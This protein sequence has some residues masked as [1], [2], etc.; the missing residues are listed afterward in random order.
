MKKIA[1]SLLLSLNILMGAPLDELLKEV[2]HLTASQSKQDKQ[3]EKKF[4]ADLKLAK[5]ELSLMK[6]SLK[7]ETQE[8]Q[9]LKD[10]FGKNK[11]TLKTMHTELDAKSINLKDLFAIVRQES[12]DFSSLLKASMTS[13][14][15]KDREAFLNELSKSKNVPT[16]EEIREFWTL[17]MQE[18]IEAGKL[19]TS[20]MQIVLSTGEKVQ[21][22]VTRVGLFSAFTQEG[23]LR[24]DESMQAFVSLIRQPNSKY[25]SYIQTYNH[26]DNTPSPILIDPTRGVLFSM[27]KERAGILDRIEQGGIIGYII[28]VLGAI[29]MAFA[30]YKYFSL[31]STN[32]K[33]GRQLVS[34]E[35]K[36]NNPL[37]RILLAFNSHKSKDIASLESKMDTAIL[38][39]LPAIQTGLPMIKLVAA[40]APLLGLLGTVTGMIETFQSI[41]L[42]GTG[43]PKLMAGGISQALMTTVLGLVVA[44]PIL[45]VFSV[46]NSQSK[47]IIEML[48]QQSSA[49]VAK[50]L[51]LI[52]TDV[53]SHDQSIN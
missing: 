17:Y 36:E 37:G 34:S 14:E 8:T 4:L 2:N 48:T 9:R 25:L 13:A 28:L 38:K 23:Y 33:M 6:A 5:K 49:L 42:F 39:E 1:L 11:I 53:K 32:L 26:L 7:K 31:F 43:D 22:K 16:I 24:Y 12:R 18:M 44:I 51:E 10:N 50:Q 52:S 30:A 20:D 27:L 40:V 45:F 21:S 15:L 35:A 29:T 41:T 46:L 19:K 3:R 47:K